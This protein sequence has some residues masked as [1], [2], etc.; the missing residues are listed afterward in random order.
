MAS[1]L[2]LCVI[3]LVTHMVKDLSSVFDAV[4]ARLGAFPC[5][6]MSVAFSTRHPYPSDL[7]M[8]SRMSRL[9]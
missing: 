7:P 5:L 2:S 6:A 9:M 8:S 3:L 1:S 4:S